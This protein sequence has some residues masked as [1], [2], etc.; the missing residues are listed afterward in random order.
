MTKDYIYPIVFEKVRENEIVYNASPDGIS[1]L[2][3]TYDLYECRI[4]QEYYDT[5]IKDKDP[6]TVSNGNFDIIILGNDTMINVMEPN[7]YPKKGGILY[8]EHNPNIE[9]INDYFKENKPTIWI[10]KHTTLVTTYDNLNNINNIVIGDGSRVD[11]PKK[12]NNV[13]INASTNILK[14]EV[15]N[16]TISRSLL[17]NVKIDNSETYLSAI[18]NSIVDNSA[19]YH[20]NIINSKT[21]TDTIIKSSQLIGVDT[22]L[23][24]NTIEDST[25]VDLTQEHDNNIPDKFNITLIDTKIES[26]SIKTTKPLEVVE[27][28]LVDFS[29]D[30]LVS[31]KTNPDNHVKSVSGILT[32][33][34]TSNVSR[35]SIVQGQLITVE[36]MEFDNHP[37]Q[38][39]PTQEPSMEL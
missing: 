26:S 12:L 24:P 30:T 32:T 7:G 34:K 21:G 14:S 37:P 23:S 31:N 11:Y 10:D 9:N 17:S 20:S 28:N 18:D 8:V 29:P 16:S 5:Y 35:F 19:I 13:T 33:D 15:T 4:S 6:E 1:S 2:N 38:Q 36:E 27:T 39:Q 25:I 3:K 22:S